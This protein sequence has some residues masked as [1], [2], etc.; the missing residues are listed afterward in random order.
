MKK[1]GLEEQKRIQLEMLVDFD[2]FCTEH[3]LRYYLHC[4]T[5]LGAVRHQGYIPWDDDIDVSMPRWDYEQFIR[6]YNEQRVNPDYEVISFLQNPDFYLPFAK[7]IH[8]RT[9]LAEAVD[10]DLKLG[11]YLDIFPLDN[12]GDTK[13]EAKRLFDEVYVLRQKLIVQN[14]K[15]IKERSLY[16]NIAIFFMKLFAG[17]NKRRGLIRQIDEKCRKYESEKIGRYIAVNCAANYG[18]KEIMPGEWYEDY[19]V[20]PFEEYRFRIPAG[21]DGNLKQ[22]YGDYMKL[23]PEEKRKS[24]HVYDAEWKDAA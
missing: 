17:K 21:Y 16:K 18:E 8:R 20:V 13:E 19:I 12:M 10:S 5:L 2:R 1:I 7:L 3:Q 22:F 11:I 9:Q 15:L 4:G 24:H 23:P 14:L 6:L